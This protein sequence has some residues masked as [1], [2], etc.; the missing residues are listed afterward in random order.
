MVGDILMEQTEKLGEEISMELQTMPLRF[1]VWDDTEKKWGAIPS[2]QIGIGLD[3][4]H[5]D[6]NQEDSRYIISQ[7]TGLKDKNGEN[8]Y[9]GDILFNGRWYIEVKYDDGEVVGYNPAEDIHCGSLHN[10]QLR[11]NIWQNPELLEEK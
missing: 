6:A 9:T 1:R 10:M 2:H 4:L 11:G 8:I 7:D 5:G 3:L